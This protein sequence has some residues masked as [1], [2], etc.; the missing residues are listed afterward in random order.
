MYQSETSK[1]RDKL[2]KYCIGDGCDIGFGGD[3]ITMTQ[4]CEFDFGSLL[5]CHGKN[6]CQCSWEE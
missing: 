6:H 5:R 4:Q 2:K 3:P 1:H